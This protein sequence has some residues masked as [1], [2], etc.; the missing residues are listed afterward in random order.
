MNKNRLT[1]LLLAVFLITML[2]SCKNR[3]KKSEI[4]LTFDTI[5]VSKKIPLLEKNDSTLPFA[6]VNINFIYPATFRTPEELA[7]LQQ[8]FVGTFFT[9]VRYDSL[10]PQE[11]INQYLE[12]YT[13]HYRTLS[14]DYYSD[15][16][17]LPEGEMPVWYWYQLNISNKIL[18][19]N[20]SI[21]SYAVKYSDYTGGAH[22]SYR[23]L[24][25][26]I[27]LNDLVT[28][29][30]EDLF[31]PDYYKPLT[32]II[33][34]LLMKKYGVTSPD[35]LISKGF[36]NLDDIA[37][38]NNFWMNDHGLHYTYNQYEIA[39]YV[40]GAI[41]VSIPYAELDSLLRP[42][43]PIERFFPGKEA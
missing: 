12:N 15:K 8:I 1:A 31:V 7:R 17:R 30:E 38:N 18:F 27:D 14:K 13:Q 28:I 41:D 36:F 6:V 16:S 34:R 33:L 3:G 43:N 32:E 2:F 19:Q 20:D 29:S 25:Y 11:A 26:N 4:P 42:D 21:L 24:Y 37:P 10:H 40:I 5:A 39:P 9:D 22:G 35:S 23:I